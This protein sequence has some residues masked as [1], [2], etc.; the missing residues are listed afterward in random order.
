MTKQGAHIQTALER[1]IEAA[2]AHLAAVQ[3]ADGAPDDETV[4]RAYM[5]TYA[6]TGCDPSV[7]RRLTSLLAGAGCKPARSTSIFFGGCAGSSDFEIHASNVATIMAGARASI[8]RSGAVDARG[9]DAGMAAWE[10]W[11][12]LPD[13]AIWYS[14]AFA[15]GVKVG[16]GG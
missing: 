11:R 9:F 8:V 7:G 12:K 1:L 4:W 16:G 2:R 6:A 10:R 3:A 15:E 14:V 5:A 13:A